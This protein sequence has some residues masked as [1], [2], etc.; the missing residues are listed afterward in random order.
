MHSVP[1]TPPNKV[2]NN[3]Y[4]LQMKEFE[5]MVKIRETLLF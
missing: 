5:M 1:L 4:I 3:K 2:Y